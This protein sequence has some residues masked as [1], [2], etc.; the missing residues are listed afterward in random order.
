MCHSQVSW[1]DCF[2][3]ETSKV[4]NCDE[5]KVSL[6]TDVAC[7]NVFAAKKRKD[8]QQEFEFA[9]GCFPKV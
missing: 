8:N 6:G 2:N 5:F 9:A 3:G 1:D 4:T 7:L